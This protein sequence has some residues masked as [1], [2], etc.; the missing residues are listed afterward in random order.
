MSNKFSIWGLGL[1]DATH[2]EADLS[3]IVSDTLDGMPDDEVV[4]FAKFVKQ[5]FKNRT[6]VRHEIEDM[7]KCCCPWD[8]LYRD[9][10]QCGGL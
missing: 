2:Q 6:A 5:Y 1:D 9:G 8:E 4:V 7:D 10:C 3:K